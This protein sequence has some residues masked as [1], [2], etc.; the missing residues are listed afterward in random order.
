MLW[1]LQ[2]LA[3]LLRRRSL[4]AEI[5]E[6]LQF[7]LDSRIRDNVADGMSVDEARRDAHRRFGSP[8]GVRDGVRDANILV[9]LESIL[10]DLRFAVRSILRRPGFAL[11]AVTTLALGIG[12]NAAIF[13]IVE[14]VLVRPLPFPESERL[15][16]ISFAQ[17][18]RPVWLYPGLADA[19][20]LA[21]R[22]QDRTFEATATFANPPL[23]LTGAGDAARVSS[24]SVT[25]DF[26]RVLRVDPA[27]GRTLVAD[28]A[29]EGAEPVAV[30]SDRLWRS[31]FGADPSVVSRRIVL[32]GVAHTVVGVM[33]QGFSYPLETEVW[34]PF[35]LQ[36]RPGT[37][38]SRPVI[39][40]LRADTTRE[41]ADAAFRA[42]I[43]TRAKEGIPPDWI[44]Q[45]MPMKDA[46]VG[47]VGT[48]LLVFSGA[49]AFVLLIACANVANLLLM[50]AVSRRHEMVTR[51]ALGASRARLIRL[52]MTEAAVL[53]TAGGALGVVLAA[54]GGPALLTLIPAGKLPRHAEIHMDPW[55]V[56]FT[57]GLVAITTVIL[58]VLPALQ[59]GRESLASVAR[60]TS[61]SSTRRSHRLRHVLV[62]SEI[63]LALMLLVGA[64]LL[65]RNFLQMRSVDPGFEPQ[66]VMTMTVNLPAARYR[67]IA[68]SQ[69]FHTR[70]LQ[71]LGSLPGVTS[72][73]AVNWMPLGLMMLRGDVVADGGVAVP[74]DY[75]VMKAAISPRYFTA[76]GIRLKGRDFSDADVAGAPKVAIV[77]ESVARQIWPNDGAIGKRISIESRP[78]PDDWLTIV[79]VAG[80]IRQTALT[81]PVV[82][83]LYQPYQQVTRPGFLTYMTFVVRAEGDVSS[84]APA[85][86]GV[87][88]AVDRDQAPQSLALMESVV[89]RTMA[90]PRFQTQLMGGFSVLALVLAALGIYGVLA[91]SVVER[92]REIGIRM[93]LGAHHGDVV[94]MVV[95]RTLVLTAFGAALGLSGASALTKF[96]ETLL[97]GIPPKDPPSFA[98]AVT[99][100]VLAALTAA[101]VP[102]LRASRVDPVVALRDM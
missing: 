48:P 51:L 88:R 24:S 80:D 23:T 82:P 39:G 19:D 94:R 38:F 100:I 89:S 50:R 22:E 17:N 73:G 79:G 91:S 97:V 7:H 75:A 101:V 27:A 62:V 59:S 41:Q 8:L 40:R 37:S 70:V 18:R 11:L 49:V 45:V 15:Q 77:S 53:S 67:A 10:Q 32:D 83:A 4:N 69:D 102:A 54:F 85:I 42:F 14:S 99:V 60:E 28:D 65:A 47:D 64:G 16:I 63:A 74:D 44:A 52:L 2:R 36:I 13:T 46:V 9:S 87:L 20:Y 58:G 21:F 78:G 66:R 29:R 93:A 84:L 92:Q 76:M 5:D 33:P 57:L 98:I 95:S 35:N 56:L 72:A 31:R 26:F 68:S 71:G 12:A 61:S 90:E 30:I 43:S 55:V 96:L 81:S 25:G 34:T 3:N 6:E 1:T 86:R